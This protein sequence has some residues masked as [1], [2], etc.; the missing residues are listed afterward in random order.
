M[1]YLVRMARASAKVVG[2]GTAGPLRSI[3][4]AALGPYDSYMADIARM[5]WT[6]PSS[7]Q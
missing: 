1:L 7:Q 4:E 2:S 3:P 5:S 6:A